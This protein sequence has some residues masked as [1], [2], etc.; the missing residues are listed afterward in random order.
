MGE[1]WVRCRRC[2]EVFEAADEFCPKCGSRYEAPASAQAEPQESFADRYAGTEF[3]PATPPPAPPMTGRR[4]PTPFILGGTGI[5]VVALLAA[6]LS[7]AWNGTSPA[8]QVVVLGTEKPTATASPLPQGVGPALAH[9][10]DPSFT[11][12]VTIKTHA[13]VDARVGGHPIAGT[14]TFVGWLSGANET[15]TF[16]QNTTA[17]QITIFNGISYSRPNS[18]AKWALAPSLPA[19]LQLRPLL[20]LTKPIELSFVG[21]DERDGVPLYH[22]HTTRY[23]S[24]DAARIALMDLSFVNLR[25]DTFA[26]DLWITA[27]GTPVNAAFSA[28]TTASDGVKL[29]DVETTYDF[30]DVGVPYAI[31]DPTATPTPTPSPSPSGRNE[32]GG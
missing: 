29:I 19:Y 32:I 13:N 23:W 27:G 28:T 5:V 1:N 22:L 21:T 25:P 7:G 15:G 2:H 20:G 18:S 8:Q 4:N 14:T 10:Q 9:L 31:M 3:A 6:A 26:L 24:P 16:T 30:G 12:A 17:V 11:A